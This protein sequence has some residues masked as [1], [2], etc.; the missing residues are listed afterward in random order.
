[1]AQPPYDPTE[2]LALI[3][4][5]QEQLDR[6]RRLVRTQPEELNPG[7]PENKQD[8]GHLTPR[9]VEVCYRLFDEGKTRYH[10]SRAMEISFQA[11]K[12]RLD[13]WKKEGGNDRVRRPLD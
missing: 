1:M 8:D 4:N 10:V 7:D 13:C 5:I 3:D 6:L 11:A 2:V 12:Y 9:G